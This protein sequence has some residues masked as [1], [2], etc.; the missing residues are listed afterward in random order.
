MMNEI[1]IIKAS[2]EKV[3]FSP[4]K[5]RRSLKRAG[6]NENIIEE[7]LRDI[8]NQLYDGITTKKIYQLAFKILRKKHTTAASKYKL[9]KAI[10]ELG[11]SGYPFEK[12]MS[13]I[14]QSQGHSV[15]NNLIM[16]GR[17][18][19][20]EVD[21]LA[22]KNDLQKVIECKYHNLQ[23][24]ICDVKIPLYVHSRFRDI[25]KN[26]LDGKRQEGWVVTNT[27]FSGDAI[28]YGICAGLNLL[29]WDYPEGKG[30]R[31]TID[32]GGLYPITCLTTLLQKEKEKLMEHGLVLC[33][34]IN[35]NKNTLV[36]IGI[37]SQRVE[38]VLKEASALGSRV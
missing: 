24:T 25:E 11:P 20:H 7:V 14:F 16:K 35:A 6:A 23:G 9:K 22:E 32:E 17:C 5:I 15:Q 8:Q 2:G 33:R 12:Y 28:Q 13:E 21:I 37:P 30:L 29:G 27:R 34:E 31:E 3:S 38:A 10:M 36:E 26:N 4:Q 1:Q 19:N 18:V